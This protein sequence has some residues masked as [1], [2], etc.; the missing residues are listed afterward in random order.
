MCDA[1]VAVVLAKLRQRRKKKKNNSPTRIRRKRRGEAK[2]SLFCKSSD[3][4]WVSR[5][6]GVSVN[7]RLER[8]K[9][10]RA[11]LEIAEAENQQVDAT[12]SMHTQ[13]NKQQHI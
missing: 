3:R 11:Q 12:L 9:L 1:D 5:S 13:Y 7:S 2:V 8:K 4:G 10:Q 6:S